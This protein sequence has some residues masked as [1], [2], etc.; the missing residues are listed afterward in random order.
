MNSLLSGVEFKS[1]VAQLEIWLPLFW[2]DDPTD[3]ILF[4]CANIYKKKMVHPL[5]SMRIY[6]AALCYIG[7]EEA[8]RHKL[9]T[10]LPL[11]STR[12]SQGVL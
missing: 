6:G 10:H 8:E 9:H 12:C 3:S 7:I 4:G 2:R 5:W 11:G 1:R